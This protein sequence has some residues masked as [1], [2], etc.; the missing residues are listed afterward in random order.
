MSQSDAMCA[1]FHHA[2]MQA[3]NHLH[4]FAANWLA[5]LEL[6]HEM[7][8]SYQLIQLDLNLQ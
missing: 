7:I 5:F 1:Q 6:P 4:L 3:N 8:Q 2:A